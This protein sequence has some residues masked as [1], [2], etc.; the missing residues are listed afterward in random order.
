MKIPFCLTELKTFFII[1]F[2]VAVALMF[3]SCSNTRFLT[4]DNKLY[5]GLAKI[6][7]TG[8]DSVEKLI[9]AR[10]KIAEIT[11]FRPNNSLL[12]RRR[13]LPP[14]GLWTYNYLKPKKEGKK[15]GWVFRNFSKTPI[16]ISTVNPELRSKQLESALFGLGFFHSKVSYT[17]KTK[18]SN[19]RKGK[20]AYTIYL[21]MPFT[22]NKLFSPEPVDSVDIFIHKYVENMKLK[23][24]DVFDVNV[25]KEEK[26]KLA[27]QLNELGYFYFGPNYLQ[28]DVDTSIAPYG[29]DIRVRKDI[30]TPDNAIA[31]YTIGEIRV[32]FSGIIHD[33][34]VTNFS[35]ADSVFFDGIYIFGAHDYLKSPVLRRS[36]LFDIGDFYS[37]SKHQG[38]IKQ[39]N[40]YGVFK[41][42]RVQFVLSDSVNHRLNLLVDLT[43]KDDVSLN[44]EGFVQAKSTSFA[45]PGMEVS[46]THGNIG[47]AANKL[48][49]KL[50]GGFEWQWGKESENNLGTNSYNVG[51]S[52]AFVFP[53]II[54]PFG[55]KP[56][57]SLLMAKTVCDLGFEFLNNVQ[58][59][60]MTSFNASFSYQW[61]NSQKITHVFSPV[62][63]NIVNLL[64]TTSEFDAIADSNIYV[65]KS[66]EEQTIL[67][68][69]Y[70]FIYDNTLRKKRGFYFQGTI[71][72]SGNLA[73][74]VNLILGETSPYKILGNV[75]S[76]FFKT[77]LD[78]RYY[79]GSVK[80][81]FVFRLYTGVGYSYGNS[82]V[83]PYIEQF[84]SGGS[85]SIRAFPA[86]SLGPG[87]YKPD[88]S[89]GIIDQTGDIKG[90]FNLEYR[91]PMSDIVYIG[92]FTDVGNVWLLN[93]D[94]NRP[95]AAF[96]VN[97]FAKQLA[98]GSGLGLRFDFDFFILRGDFG[99]PIR[100]TYE[101]DS[102]YWINDF[103]ES[104]SDFTF[105][106]AI[107]YPF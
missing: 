18:K 78:L 14:L 19:Q 104:I 7:V 26:S 21:G 39:L 12:G 72:T 103:S 85:A 61:K 82:I 44:L 91:F 99:F 107:G 1:G 73:N 100:N 70:S 89:N 38:T 33:T 32:Q 68:L 63:V 96:N 15:G 71:G 23:P 49:L 24:G 2:V 62:R 97:T 52:S 83:M 66:F 25:I 27:G 69:T 13:N 9:P 56:P 67:G 53:R 41:N 94:E 81:G 92:F 37:T 20:I 79:T 101:T 93:E 65:S 54:L 48:Q 11:Y 77:S 16:L 6:T 35:I 95:G 87:G 22:I 55:W 75:Y 64:E 10:E 36:I 17:V 51:L 80:K 105:N 30:D 58:Y 88:E 8:K 45:G 34:S 98:I 31:K 28:F 43:P 84:Y 40:N 57:S 60:R 86:R 74:V 47:R 42:V 29:L 4:D 50:D 59:Y 46:L 102:K 76:Q 90:E 5:T 3:G 106:I